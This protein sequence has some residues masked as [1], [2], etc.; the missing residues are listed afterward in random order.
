MGLSGN[1]E[2]DYIF[3]DEIAKAGWDKKISQYFAD[4]WEGIF[5]Q[6]ELVYSYINRKFGHRFIPAITSNNAQKMVYRPNCET[7]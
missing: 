4:K 5:N 1:D 7:C 6:S 3:R 2:A